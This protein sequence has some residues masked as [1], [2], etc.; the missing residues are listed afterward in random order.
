MYFTSNIFLWSWKPCILVINS[1]FVHKI[2][3]MAIFHWIVTMV[4]SVEFCGVYNC[5]Q[6][7]DVM[8]C[9]CHDFAVNFA[10]FTK[11]RHI[12]HHFLS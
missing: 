9:L 5:L 12:F 10:S 11:V 1:I 7:H 6:A 2:L 8:L 4:I 3:Q